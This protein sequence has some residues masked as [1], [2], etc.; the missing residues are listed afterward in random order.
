MCTDDEPHTGF[1]AALSPYGFLVVLLLKD[2][3]LGGE[4]LRGGMAV[5]PAHHLQ[6]LACHGGL[7]LG[8][9]EGGRGILFQLENLFMG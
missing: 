4:G 5:V 9:R 1:V 7:D 8:G 6:T 3:V 2:V